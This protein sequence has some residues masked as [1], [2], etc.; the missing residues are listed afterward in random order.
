LNILPAFSQARLYLHGKK[1]S[2]KIS[3]FLPVDTSKVFSNR[4]YNGAYSLQ[5][6]G[7]HNALFL[8]NHAKGNLSGMISV[9]KE[10]SSQT[11]KL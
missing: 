1:V 7:L 6:Y 9:I 11:R 5:R 10:L 4:H 2:W 3:S 8:Q